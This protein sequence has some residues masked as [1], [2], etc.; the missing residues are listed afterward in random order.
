MKKRD[1]LIGAIVSLCGTIIDAVAFNKHPSILLLG[2]G[3]LGALIIGT[4]LSNYISMRKAEMERKK[5][6]KCRMCD[7][8]KARMA[9]E[10]GDDEGLCRECLDELLPLID[11]LEI[12]AEK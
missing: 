8:R 1:W 3:A 7:K 4:C 12:E 11:N 10:F 6:R 9:L 5:G 2:I